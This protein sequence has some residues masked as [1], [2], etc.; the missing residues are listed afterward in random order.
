MLLTNSLFLQTIES[1]P[2]VAI[3]LIVPNEDGE[4]LLGYRLNK[5]AQNSWFVPGGRIRKGETLDQAFRRIV[6][7][8]LG[9]S[10][11]SRAD[12]DLLGVYEHLYEDNVFGILGVSTH[13]VVLGYRLRHSIDTRTLPQKQHSA[14]RWASASQIKED[15]DVHVNTRAYFTAD[16]ALT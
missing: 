10:D 9:Y 14:Y 3:D 4:Y 13:Y 2:L 12:A 7:D 11:L 16:S 5:P 8:E 1:T 15:V 6:Q